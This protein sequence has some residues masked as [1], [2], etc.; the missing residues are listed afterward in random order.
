M[1]DVQHV[2][3]AQN[4]NPV[5]PGMGVRHDQEMAKQREVD[6]WDPTPVYQQIAAFL[7]ADIEAGTLAP[8]DPLPSELVIQQEFGVARGTA[9]AVV[10]LLREEGLVVTL[11]GR[12][13]FVKPE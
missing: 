9:R 4:V 5:K 8:G 3:H 1:L 6:Q 10:R 13:T 2:Q 11:P 12:G 7:R